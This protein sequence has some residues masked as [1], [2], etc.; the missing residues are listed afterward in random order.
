MSAIEPLPHWRQLP[1]QQQP[2]WPEA[3]ALNTVLSQIRRLPSLVTEAEIRRLRQSLVAVEQGQSFILQ[4][5]DC[6]ESFADCQAERLKNQLKILLQ[7]SLIL[8]HG[9]EQPVVRIGRIGGQYAKPRSAPTE[10]RGDLTL[11]SYRGDNVN[12]VEFTAQARKPDPQ[13][14]LQGHYLAALSMNHLRALIEGGFA[15]L[16]HPQHWEFEWMSH[17]PQAEEYRRRVRGV[18]DAIRFMER[19]GPAP[20]AALER[21]ELYSSHEALLLDYENAQRFSSAGSNPAQADYLLSTHLPWVGVRTADPDGAHVAFFAG[22]ANPIGVKIGPDSDVERI[23]ALSERLNP[24]NES[25]KLIF[26]HRFGAGKTDGLLPPLVEAMR[27]RGRRA[28]WVCDPMHG[29]T[30]STE[31]GF[32]TRPFSLIQQ[33]IAEAFAVHREL[34]SH[35]GGVHLELTGDNVT[36]CL[37]GA[38]DLTPQDLKV[39]YASRVDPRLNPEQAL[40]LALEIVKI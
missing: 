4:G 19:M 40:E 17:S 18:R 7:M 36:E 21:V 1:A 12:D 14:L 35:L 31:N 8:V 23:L 27:K 39:A 24:E 6:A 3:S 15:D 25:G 2:E 28:I 32:K 34:G 9:R 20:T 33:E 10:T 22:I 26:I 13:K 37:G 38:R 30:Q 16:H 5:G 29:N 11:P